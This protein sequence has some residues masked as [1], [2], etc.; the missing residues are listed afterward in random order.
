MHP[1]QIETM[2]L[3]E[4][5]LLTGHLIDSFALHSS[6]PPPTS[7]SKFDALLLRAWDI[8]AGLLASFAALDF[9]FAVVGCVTRLEASE[10]REENCMQRLQFVS[11][12][13]EAAQ[14]FLGKFHC[15]M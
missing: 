11:E 8:H 7:P 6:I 1:L 2:A 12:E 4:V 14:I 13:E 10:T 3:G 9:A 5:Q 15:M